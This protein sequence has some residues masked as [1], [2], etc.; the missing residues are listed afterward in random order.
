MAVNTFKTLGTEQH[1]GSICRICQ[2]PQKDLLV[3]NTY[4]Y[5]RTAL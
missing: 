3:S 5:W 4:E 2:M 1:L